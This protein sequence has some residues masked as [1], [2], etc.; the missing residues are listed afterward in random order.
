MGYYFIRD[1]AITGEK[2]LFQERRGKGY[3]P[4]HAIFNKCMHDGRGYLFIVSG[5]KGGHGRGYLFIVSVVKGGHLSSE[6]CAV[7]G[8]SFHTIIESCDNTSTSTKKVQSECE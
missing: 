4:V 3:L 2:L 8:C 5:V 1:V 6:Y 7:C